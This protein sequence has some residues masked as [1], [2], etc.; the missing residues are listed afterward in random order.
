[1]AEDPTSK[2]TPAGLTHLNE[3]GQMHMVDV[4]EKASTHRVAVAEAR[5][6]LGA[7]AK[8][9][10][11]AGGGKGDVLAAARFAGITA[12]KKTSELIPLCH[13]LGLSHV[14]V[15]ITPRDWGLHVEARAE[16]RG[17]TGVE[18]EAMTAASVAALT[19]YDMLKAVERG[20]V[21]EAI[22]L[23]EKLGGRSGHWRRAP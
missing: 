15:E 4:G 14:A 2:N 5:V 3:R 23:V 8:R 13:P 19:I 9:A 7:E 11:E 12:A 22:G 16:T 18:M 20:I 6:L 21:V 10:L 1:M 17:P